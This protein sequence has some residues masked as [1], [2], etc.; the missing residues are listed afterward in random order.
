MKYWTRIIWDFKM[1]NH[2]A[3]L[4][5]CK[6][7]LRTNFA[8]LVPGT[9]LY[10][11][12]CDCVC[13]DG[14]LSNWFAVGN[15]IQLGCRMEPVQYGPYDGAHCTSRN[16]GC[17]LRKWSIHRP[18]LCGWCHITSWNAGSACSYY[19]NNAG[20]GGGLW[21]SEKLVKNQNTPGSPIPCLAQ[22]S[23]WQ[24]DMLKWS[25]PLSICVVWSTPQ[26]VAEARFCIGLA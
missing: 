11:D 13:A 6:C 22:Q 18:G 4:L 14:V 8:R 7:I 21:S 26:V 24:M 25:T 16:S 17:N 1:W 3:G 2:A 15:G 10:T 9:A 12:T 20:R 5:S 19:D 23:R